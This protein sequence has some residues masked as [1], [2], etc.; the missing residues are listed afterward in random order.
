[1]L[2]KALLP[3]DNDHQAI[4]ERLDEMLDD[5]EE[6]QELSL[7]SIRMAAINSRTHSQAWSNNKV[8]PYLF[9]VGDIG[10]IPPGQDFGSFVVFQNVFKDDLAVLDAVNASHAEHTQW[11]T[12]GVPG[13][14]RVPLQAFPA[15]NDYSGYVPP[16]FR[17]LM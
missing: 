1:M 14:T 9:T 12:G 2:I 5:S 8:P 11:E 15:F 13:I 10:Y 3:S 16:V 6:V 17:C 4:L 7:R